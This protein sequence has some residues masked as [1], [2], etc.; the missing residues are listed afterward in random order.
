MRNGILMA[1]DEINAKG[2][3]LGRQLVADVQD[4]SNTTDIA[5]NATNKLVSEDVAGIIGPHYSSL[6]LSLIHI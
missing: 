5:I 4:C 2:G 3:V 6:G 1:I